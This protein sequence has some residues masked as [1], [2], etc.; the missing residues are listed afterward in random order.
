MEGGG[1]HGYL[2]SHCDKISMI[3]CDTNMS[4]EVSVFF[5]FGLSCSTPRVYKKHTQLCYSFVLNAF[6]DS[7]PVAASAARACERA[8]TAVYANTP[9]PK[10]AVRCHCTDPSHEIGNTTI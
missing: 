9:P 7:W 8:A 4:I 2:V 5:L 1:M 10:R 3:L 6:S